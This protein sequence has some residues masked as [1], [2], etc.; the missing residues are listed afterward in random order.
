MG[1]QGEG[2]SGL[3]GKSILVP[4]VQELAKV[5]CLEKIPERYIQCEDDPILEAL[6]ESS[7]EDIQVPI[8]NMQSLITGDET[9][10]QKLH[11]A[12]QEWGFFQLIEHGI[13]T[14]LLGKFKLETQ[15]FFNLPIEEKKKYWQTPGDIEGFGQGFVVS[16]EQKL[17][18]GDM[19]YLTTYPEHLR[20]PN[21]LPVLPL[22]YRDTLEN[23]SAEMRKL[24]KKILKL[25][26]K[27][28]LK[29]RDEVIRENVFGEGYQSVRMNYYPPCPH[30][31]KVLGLM[32]HTDG[33]VLIT[34]LLQINEVEGLQIMKDSKWIGIKPL[35]NAFVINIGDV[36]EM[37]SNGI[38]RSVLHRAVVN[39]SKERLSVASFLSPALD[40]EIGP[41]PELVTSTSPA[42]FRTMTMA[43]YW[44]YFLGRPLD[45]KKCIDYLRILEEYNS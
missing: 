37:M 26:A 13:S 34:I 24:A 45:G 25:M 19:F 21:L 5:G 43:D 31:D 27:A 32:P 7:H 12:C 33:P 3:L 44:K 8:I 30:P 16:E 17:N 40:Q 6:N 2:K 23:Y 39:E 14:S 1:A 41:I 18:W 22:P 42:R 20:R 9:E 36:L 35:P 38:Y 15:E 4:N 11:L 28:L 10:L 29:V